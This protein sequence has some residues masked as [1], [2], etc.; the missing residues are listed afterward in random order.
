ME[1]TSQEALPALIAEGRAGQYAFIYIDGLHMPQV[2]TSLR[3]RHFKP[4]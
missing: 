3:L 1:M 4:P 2:R